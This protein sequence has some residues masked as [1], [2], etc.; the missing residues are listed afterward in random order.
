MNAQFME[1]IAK[2]RLKKLLADN[3]NF[4][5]SKVEYAH[6]KDRDIYSI[7]LKMLKGGEYIITMIVGRNT[8]E[9]ALSD[10]RGNILEH[11][12]HDGERVVYG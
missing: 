5:S 11:M 9:M 4:E 6:D 1:F 2:S 7:S 12:L 10:K 8:M 3:K